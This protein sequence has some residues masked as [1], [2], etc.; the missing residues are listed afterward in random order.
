L[1]YCYQNYRKDKDQGNTGLAE[2]RT[3]LLQYGDG[4]RHG[5]GRNEVTDGPAPAP[6]NHRLIV[7]YCVKSNLSDLGRFRGS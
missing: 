2:F 7:G 1:R 5:N 6:G 3:Q 4:Q